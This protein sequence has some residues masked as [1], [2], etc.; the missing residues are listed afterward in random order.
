LEPP[1]GAV[2]VPRNATGWG[3]GFGFVTLSSPAQLTQALALSGTRWH[4][5]EV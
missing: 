1:E 4:G 3:K 2:R 5:R